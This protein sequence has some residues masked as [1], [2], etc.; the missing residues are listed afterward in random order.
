[1]GNL[2]SKHKN[3]WFLRNLVGILII[4]FLISVS[5]QTISFI[6]DKTN[7]YL[8]PKAISSNPCFELRLRIPKQIPL[9]AVNSD[10]NGKPITIWAWKKEDKICEYEQITVNIK[11]DSGLVFL[12]SDKLET[13]PK[14]VLPLGNVEEDAPRETA[15]VFLPLNGISNGNVKFT[16]ST[17]T[18]ETTKCCYV[19][20]TTTQSSASFILFKFLDILLGTTLFSIIAFVFSG[21]KYYLDQEN[22][23]RED[24]ALL[25]VKITDLENKEEDLGLSVVNLMRDAEKIERTEILLAKFIQ[26]R[27]NLDYGSIWSANL[28]KE[29]AHR[30]G[31][32]DF[33]EWINEVSNWLGFPSKEDIAVLVWFSNWLRSSELPIETKT[34]NDLL[35]VFNVLGMC[36]LSV[37][38]EKVDEILKKGDLL[39][40]SEIVRKIWEA[41]YENGQAS[42]RFLLTYIKNEK[43]KNNLR[44]WNS[45]NPL[46]PNNISRKFW[47][48]G[49]TVRFHVPIEDE[50]NM[51][52]NHL[53]PFGPL[54]AQDDP[55]L[56]L[57]R[58]SID[59]DKSNQVVGLFWDKHPAWENSIL[60]PVSAVYIV[61]P[62]MGTTAFIWTGRRERRYWGLRPS[63][64]LYFPLVGAASEDK[65]W[66]GLETGL[67]DSLLVS[68]AEDPYW[69]LGS[70]KK[71]AQERIGKFLLYFYKEIPRVLHLLDE[72]RLPSHEQMIFADMLMENKSAPNYD[73]NE[74]HRLVDDILL[75]MGDAALDR[76]YDGERFECY[77]WIE[78]KDSPS[79]RDWFDIFGKLGLGSI[80]RTKIFSSEKEGWEHDKFPKVI[81]SWE[82][83]DLRNLLKYRISQSRMNWQERL[84]GVDIEELIRRAD[85]SP[86]ELI[87]LGNEKL[88]KAKNDRERGM[89][90]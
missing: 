44:K 83:D 42:G 84:P 22:K 35:R 59:N 28:R 89:H 16:L 36:G 48:W 29:I 34:L 76:L 25:D 23:K 75:V 21:V 17:N 6:L 53:H 86:R 41:W 9:S 12:N 31:K 39:G 45:K 11:N 46:P 64:S 24:I 49:D 20:N 79:L 90:V 88:L 19:I 51:L 61:N 63:L 33:N 4:Y 77:L 68:L 1:M 32:D 50:D 13:A 40:N 57:P 71:S 73:R 80:G 66:R 67:A 14:F 55:R 52:K 3:N 5:Y 62:G 58:A 85:K 15:F 65:T 54:R 81:I 74:F 69:L 87:R 8:P 47:P 18:G 70:N 38:E 26:L 7:F 56:A 60:L 30:L 2:L 43:V 82:E 27:S 72:L 78:I 37:I 10:G